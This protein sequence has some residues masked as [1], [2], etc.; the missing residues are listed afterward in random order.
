MPDRDYYLKDDAKLKEARAAY[1]AHIE[2]ML[3]MAGQSQSRALTPRRFS[4]WKP[5]WRKFNGPG[6]KTAIRS[7]PTTRRR[8]RELARADAGI[9]L[10]ALSCTAPASRAKST[11]V[12][13]SQPSYFTGLG[14][15]MN[16]TPLPVWKAYFKWRVL[17]AFAPY[18]SKTFVDERFAFTGG[19]L[20]GVPE[21]RAA[22]EA[23][24]RACSTAAWARRWASSMSRNI[25]RRRTRRA[26]RRWC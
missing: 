13:V 8:Y 21:N 3:G 17:S 20:R 22:L 14:K 26:C 11:T 12:I 15:L 2:K 7:R 19:V 9:R 10:A 18:L 16:G 24:H 25:S 23:R 4:S 6:W 5:H 1:R